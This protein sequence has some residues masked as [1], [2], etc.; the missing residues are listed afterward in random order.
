MLLMGSEHVERHK[1]NKCQQYRM[2]TVFE[3]IKLSHLCILRSSLTC[4]FAAVQMKGMGKFKS[5]Q[6]YNKKSV[7]GVPTQ[8]SFSKMALIKKATKIGMYGGLDLVCSQTHTQ[9]AALS[10]L[11]LNRSGGRSKMKNLVWEVK[12]RRS[13]TSLPADNTLTQTPSA[14]CECVTACVMGQPSLSERT[15]ALD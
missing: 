10:L 1:T 2:Y 9:L 13:L 8:P 4:F 15:F 3:S 11:L 12:M 14:I 7:V 6:E 5:S